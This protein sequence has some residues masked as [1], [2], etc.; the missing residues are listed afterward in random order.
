MRV[1]EILSRQSVL[2]DEAIQVGHGRTAYDFGIVVIFL[3]QQ[4]D[5]AESRR[6]TGN[7]GLNG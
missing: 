5:M 7:R 2:G 4:D 6:V 3:D 1:G